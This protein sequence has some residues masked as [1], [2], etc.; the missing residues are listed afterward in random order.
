MLGGNPCH[1]VAADKSPRGGAGPGVEFGARHLCPVGNHACKVLGVAVAG[2]V[3]FEGESL[4]TFEFS[5]EGFEVADFDTKE[6]FDRA[7]VE[8][9]LFGLLA[10]ESGEGGHNF[11]EGHDGENV[12]IGVG[13][14]R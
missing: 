11:G 3:E 2:G 9:R 12:E 7:V 13:K 1:G 4:L 14:A 5:G 8:E 6:R 10:S